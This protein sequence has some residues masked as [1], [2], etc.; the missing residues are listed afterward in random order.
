MVKVYDNLQDE[1]KAKNSKI[2]D[3]ETEV[4]VAKIE[5]SDIESEFQSERVDYLDTIRKLEKQLMLQ[6]QI[7]NK[8]QPTIRRDCNYFN[9]DKIKI[10]SEYSEESDTWV[11]PDL[12]IERT[13]LP[14]AAPGKE[15]LASIKPQ[16]V[17]QESLDYHERS[18]TDKF[19]S[20]LQRSSNDEFSNNYFK[21]KR[22]D[23]LL[24][25]S[26]SS[27]GFNSSGN[28]NTGK[29]PGGRISPLPEPQRRPQ[30]LEA[31]PASA[32]EKKRKKK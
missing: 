3:L 8:I 31:L 21:P 22:L 11:I 18:D 12:Q 9:I 29:P 14:K 15:T 1:I 17:T 20:H 32:F 27:N 6:N 10:L 19:A 28:V 26:S 5:V 7:L 25:T 2:T 23:K 24:S 16:S 30:K 13:S 4:E